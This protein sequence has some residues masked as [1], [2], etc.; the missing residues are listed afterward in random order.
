MDSDEDVALKLISQ[1]LAM[2]EVPMLE[3]PDVLCLVIALKTHS[4]LLT[5]NTGIL[6]AVRFHPD[7][8][9]VKV[10]TALDVLENLVLEGVLRISSIDEYIE[11]VRTYEAQTGHLFSRRRLDESRERV[12]SWLRGR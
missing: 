1:L 4:C 10:L 11:E 3:R 6:R 12:L 7:L 2:P 8:Q 5:E 9:D